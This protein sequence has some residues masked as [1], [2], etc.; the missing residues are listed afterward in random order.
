MSW[1]VIFEWPWKVKFTF[2]CMLLAPVSL[3]MEQ[4]YH[5]VL[6]N[7]ARNSSRRVCHIVRFDFEKS[8]SIKVRHISFVYIS[9]RSQDRTYMIYTATEVWALSYMYYNRISYLGSLAVPV[10]LT[11][12]LVSS[13]SV[14]IGYMHFRLGQD[15]VALTF[16]SDIKTQ[17]LSL[18]LQCTW[19]LCIGLTSLT[20]QACIQDVT[21]PV[22]L[23]S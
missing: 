23:V 21:V 11:I 2:T 15:Q 17:I 16:T 5:V 18:R 19:P 6:S 3:R 4:C 8:N 1:F 10:N 9:D 22:P 20:W 12:G 7:T 14:Y 13:I